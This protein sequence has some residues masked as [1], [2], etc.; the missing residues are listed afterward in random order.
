MPTPPDNGPEIEPKVEPRIEPKVEPR[1]T[2]PSVGP[3][4]N[5][6]RK[7]PD[8]PYAG[9]LKD[10][11]DDNKPFYKTWWFWTAVS[12]VAIGGAGAGAYVALKPGE[13]VTGFGAQVTIP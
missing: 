6:P 3:R 2:E 11:N 8:D 5:E 12:A 7:V 4:K 1:K 10:Q 9:L 13:Q